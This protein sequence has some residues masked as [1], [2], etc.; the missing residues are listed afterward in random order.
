VNGVQFTG[1]LAPEAL[2]PPVR[3]VP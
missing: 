1:S 3:A 2:P